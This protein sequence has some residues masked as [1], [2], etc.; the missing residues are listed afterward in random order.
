MGKF[1]SCVLFLYIP[2]DPLW[3]RRIDPIEAFIEFRF[4]AHNTNGASSI[5]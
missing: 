2:A 5:S 4:V 1:C 3:P